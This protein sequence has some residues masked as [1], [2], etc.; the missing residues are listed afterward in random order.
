MV[1]WRMWLFLHIFLRIPGNFVILINP[2]LLLIFFWNF[3]FP[4]KFN[5]FFWLL[6]ESIVPIFPFNPSK[7][8]TVDKKHGMAIHGIITFYPI[9]DPFSSNCILYHHRLMIIIFIVYV[10]MYSNS[11]CA[12]KL[13]RSSSASDS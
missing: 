11:L 10:R 13:F 7:W 5:H 12:T 3:D 9:T 4:L 1:A 8:T 2:N 6:I